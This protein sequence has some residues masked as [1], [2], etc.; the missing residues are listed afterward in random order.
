MVYM[1]YIIFISVM[2]NADIHLQ[3]F[4]ALDSIVTYYLINV[5]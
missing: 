1:V 5:R 2:E 4:K 3:Y